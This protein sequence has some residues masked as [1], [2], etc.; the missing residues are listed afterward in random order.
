VEPNDDWETPEQC[1]ANTALAALAVNSLPLV[2]KALE[3]RVDTCYCDH[4]DGCPHDVS[5]KVLATVAD[6]AKEAL[7]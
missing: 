4:K 6:A 5:A 7:G 2:V 3:S 1:A